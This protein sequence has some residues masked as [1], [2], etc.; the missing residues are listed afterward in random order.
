ML[1]FSVTSSHQTDLKIKV[2]IYGESGAG[3]T[4]LCSTAPNPLI[5]SAEA[6]LLSLRG[7]DIP[8]VEVGSLPEVEEVYNWLLQSGEADGIDTVCIDSI[9]EIGEIVLAEAKARSKDPRQAYG[10]TIDKVLAIVRKFR[11]LKKHVYMTAKLEGV[12]DEITGGIKYGPS[13]PG[14]KLGN[15]LPFFFDEVFR[16]AVA[17][18]EKVGPYRFLQTSLDN[19]YIAKDRSGALDKIEEPNLTNVFRKIKEQTNGNP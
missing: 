3:K 2:L 4:V 1:K 16:L 6:G 8:V 13:M 14:T 15:Q 10:E 9:S 5:I 12:K 18:D 11:G 17:V 19:R 7:Q